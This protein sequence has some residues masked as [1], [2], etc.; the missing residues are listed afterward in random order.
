MER[1]VDADKLIETIEYQCETDRSD[2]ALK[3]CK[4]FKEVINAEYNRRNITI[5]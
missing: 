4:W 3:W 5:K 2:E 1:Y